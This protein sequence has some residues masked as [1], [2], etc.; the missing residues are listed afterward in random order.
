[1]FI[2]V[3]QPLTPAQYCCTFP[4]E[5]LSTARE[6]RSPLPALQR[7]NGTTT[8]LAC[9]L[10]AAG[11]TPELYL[12]NAANEVVEQMFVDKLSYEV[13]AVGCCTAVGSDSLVSF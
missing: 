13:R 7:T 4:L 6:L 10:H 12:Y 1:M 5:P 11:H 9:V 3:P 8:E 2:E